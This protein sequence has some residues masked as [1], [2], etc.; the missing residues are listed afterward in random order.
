MPQGFCGLVLLFYLFCLYVITV[1]FILVY[2]HNTHQVLVGLSQGVGSLAILFY[3]ILIYF[4]LLFLSLSD[5]AMTICYKNSIYNSIAC[6]IAAAWPRW[7]STCVD[8]ACSSSFNYCSL[9]Y[10]SYTFVKDM[11]CIHNKSSSSSLS[12]WYAASCLFIYYYY[13]RNIVFNYVS[14]PSWYIGGFYY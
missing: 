13:Q 4:R 3:I 10:N 2:C 12:A 11:C 1:Y 14:R 9:I 6:I 7:S 5:D 8:R